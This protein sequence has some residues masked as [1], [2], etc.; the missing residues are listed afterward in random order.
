MLRIFQD[1]FR[2]NIFLFIIA[3]IIGIIFVSILFF[4][5]YSKPDSEM[6][7]DCFSPIFSMILLLYLF[8]NFSFNKSVKK[9]DFYYSI[10]ISRKKLFISKYLFSLIE[11]SLS[12]LLLLATL[13]LDIYF[14][15]HAILFY[16][17]NY[18][19]HDYD[20]LVVKFIEI[21]FSSI[22][23]FS[24]VLTFYFKASSK[25]D[26]FIYVV[27]AIAAP[28]LFNNVF[29]YISMIFNTWF[30]EYDPYLL[31]LTRYSILREIIRFDIYS[32]H[33]SI[34]YISVL[35]IIVTIGLMLVTIFKIN[36]NMSERIGKIDDDIFGY[37][38]FIPFTVI[39][40][41]LRTM[42]FNSMLLPFLAVIVALLYILFCIKNKGLVIPK[43]DRIRV[44]VTSLIYLLILGMVF[45]LITIAFSKW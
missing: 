18:V 9:S 7:L 44:L 32:L 27:F 35:Y 33:D 34:F 5:N 11:I 36:D 10:P 13:Y 31:Y 20:A 16:Y 37:N 2:K 40:I 25:L 28:F 3:N 42:R 43:K 29:E 45:I 26:G 4:F 30:Y 15:S 22:I 17:K 39:G 21:Y 19:F 1:E 12:F 38:A 14:E 6:V 41:E 8:R 23:C 24:F